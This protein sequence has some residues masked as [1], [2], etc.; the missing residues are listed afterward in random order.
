MIFRVVRAFS[1]LMARSLAPARSLTWA[2]VTTTDS[3]QPSASTAA[4]RP[5]PL[6]FFPPWN[7]RLSLPT[8]SAALTI[9]ESTMTAVGSPSPPRLTRRPPRRGGGGGPGGAPRPPLDAVPGHVEHR[10]QH[11][12][13]IVHHRPSGRQH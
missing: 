4:C 1:R 2:P 11:R 5:L 12:P 6:I 7:P 3:S 9:W 10:V 13:Q 8:V